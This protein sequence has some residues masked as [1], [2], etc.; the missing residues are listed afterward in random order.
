MKRISAALASVTLLAIAPAAQAATTLVD[1]S[2]GTGGLSAGETSYATFEGG[3]TGGVFG[4]SFIF[5]TGSN[6]LG[7]DPAVGAMGDIY[8]SVLGGGLATFDFASLGG[9]TQLGLDYGSADSYNTFTLYLSDGSTDIFSGQDIIN[10]G[11][12]DG[13]QTSARTNGRLTFTAG[14]NLFI[15]RISLASGQNSLEADNFGIVASAVPEPATWAM[16][17]FG[18]GGIGFA[19]RRRKSAAQRQRMRIA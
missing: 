12:A 8:L 13:N 9:L 7:A 14:P 17:L 5:Q 19:L 18:F 3:D 6:G 4:N 1:F 10:F 16:L 15:N 2:D 11:S